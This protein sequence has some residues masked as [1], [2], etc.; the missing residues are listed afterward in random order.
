MINEK[1]QATKWEYESFCERFVD[2][3]NESFITDET[4]DD[5]GEMSAKQL[6]EVLARYIEEEF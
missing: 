5:L 4:L 1:T 6:C 3:I 2:F